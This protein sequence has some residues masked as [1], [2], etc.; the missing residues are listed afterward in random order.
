MGVRINNTFCQNTQK[1]ITIVRLEGSYEHVEDNLLFC[2]KLLSKHLSANNES[3]YAILNKRYETVTTHGQE[4]G[5]NQ[6]A[7]NSQIA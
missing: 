6:P 2:E 1:V 7:W 4:M 3:R 5:S